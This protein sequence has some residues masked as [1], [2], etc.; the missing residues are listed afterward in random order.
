MLLPVIATRGDRVRR[1]RFSIR[2]DSVLRHRHRPDP[3]G[4]E[5]LRDTVGPTRRLHARCPSVAPV[6]ALVSPAQ[7]CPGRLY[8]WLQCRRRRVHCDPSRCPLPPRMGPQM[9]SR[10]RVHSSASRWLLAHHAYERRRRTALSVSFFRPC[11]I[12]WLR[13]RPC[14]SAA[15]FPGVR[16][17]FA[18]IHGYGRAVVG[19]SRR[20]AGAYAAQVPVLLLFITCPG[21][22]CLPIGSDRT[23]SSRDHAL[24]QIGSIWFRPTEP[25]LV[26]LALVGVAAAILGGR[27]FGAATSPADADLVRN[28]PRRVVPRDHPTWGDRPL[29]GPTDR[30][31]RGSRRRCLSPVLLSCWATTL[32]GFQK[33]PLSRRRMFGRSAPC[34][35]CFQR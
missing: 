18:L 24:F 13:V 12:V 15:V 7:A 17:G 20:S 3:E 16:L 28:R 21:F 2:R 27:R 10:W 31:S 30:C 33:S 14:A 35:T 9:R 34:F 1:Y 23:C 11:R 29:S 22:R 8:A 26:T 32:S 5:A 25:V 4:F 6:G 19:P